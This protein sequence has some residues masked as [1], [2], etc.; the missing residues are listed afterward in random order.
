MAENLQEQIVVKESNGAKALTP[1]VNARSVV[2]TPNAN[3]NSQPVLN[4]LIM[5]F[6]EVSDEFVTWGR[7]VKARDEQLRAFWHTEPMLAGAVYATVTRNATFQ[8]EIVNTDP[9]KR[10]HQTRS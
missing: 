8:W 6:A 7:N 4:S 10:P 2:H 9:S 3:E 5:Q 1:K